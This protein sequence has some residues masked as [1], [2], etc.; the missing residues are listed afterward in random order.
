[1]KKIIYTILFALSFSLTSCNFL[2]IDPEAGLDETQVFSTWDNY[3]AY[4]NNVY[5]GKEDDYNVNI[6]LTY[7]MYI[8][9]NNRR[10]SWN[11][12]TDMCD[13][14]RL[15]RA[16]QIK[17]GALGENAAEWTTTLSRRPISYSMFRMIRVCNKTIE[18]VDKLKNGK[19]ED[20]DDMLGQAYFVRALAHFTLCRIFGGMPYI[21]H[22]LEADDNWDMTRLTA[23][24]T[25]RRCAEDLDT[26][27]EYFV[28]AGKV[29]RDPL[30]GDNGH[31]NVSDMNLPNGV[32]A[33]SLKA[34][35]LL[36]A[37][38][39][40]NNLNGPADW[41]DAAVACGEAINIAE[42]YGYTLLNFSEWNKNY[43]GTTYTNEHIWAYNYGSGKINTSTFSAMFAYP[44]SNYTNAS[45]DC[46]TQ[47]F[48]D[49]FETKYG[50][51]LMTEEERAEAIALGHYHDQ[52]PYAG[53]DPRFDK[54]I[55]HDG[56]VVAGCKTGIN[57]HY[58]P[59]SKS[60]PITTLNSNNRTFGITWGSNDSKG[61]SNTGYYVN[62]R[63][64]GNLGTGSAHQHT[65]PLI[66]LAELYLNYAEAVNEVY[67]P[68][69]KAGSCQLTSL[70][71]VNKIRRRA[72]MPDVLS[73]FT[74]SAELFRE[75][76]RNER[77]VELAFEGHHYY[78]DIRRW[79]IAPKTMSQTL[80]GMY[81]EKVPV[82]DEYPAGRRYE[83]RA[84][85]SNRQSTWKE[86]M[87]YLP[88][89]TDEANKMKN[90]VNNEVW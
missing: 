30:S 42:E 16:Q 12:I 64:N 59:D 2:D 73:K 71:A 47:N 39:E 23:N 48:V 88:F 52:N 22:V 60:W 74:G 20:I 34:R 5:E 56:S 75:R 26:A 87:Y 43:Y 82:S 69:G 49:R 31:L 37:A 28:A 33:K 84:I 4:F 81:I 85:P 15:I 1:M 83:R 63:W 70:E 90:F 41:E 19:K 46:P 14:G 61:Y 18:N 32:A 86:S 79:K 53:R 78:Y 62:K 27:Y 57:I 58:D 9:F 51:P 80:M 45:G 66:R 11:S 35:C 8:D 72:G 25:Y 17:A 36:Y 3:L 6:K 29:R 40:L 54:T 77:C 38:S 65:D 50:D 89:P 21:D 24:E 55:L 68:D 10:F 7:P 67:G 76:I 13:T 44:V